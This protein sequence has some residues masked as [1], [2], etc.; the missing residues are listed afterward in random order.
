MKFPQ[1]TRLANSPLAPGQSLAASCSCGWVAPP[2]S[3]QDR[4]GTQEL[5]VQHVTESL[6]P[7]VVRALVARQAIVEL[8]R[9]FEELDHF[10]WHSSN[11]RL[12]TLAWGWWVH[13]NRDSHAL[14]VL[15]AA[16][17]ASEALPVFRSCFEHSLFLDALVRHGESAVDAA[18]AEQARQSKNFIDAAKRGPAA[19]ALPL[20]PGAAAPLQPSPDAAWTQKIWSICE[21]YGANGTLYMIYRL[22]CSMTH[23]TF[24]SAA[25]YL[26]DTKSIDS[27]DVFKRAAD[28]NFETDIIFWT[29]VFLIWAFDAFGKLLAQPNLHDSVT[30]YRRE[31]GVHDIDDFSSL[32]EFGTVDPGMSHERMHVILFGETSE[33]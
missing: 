32:S 29:A 4:D 31:L 6:N 12:M 18:L 30:A 1:H 22:V 9:K 28:L 2:L 11:A 15:F 5:W 7:D 24:S 25:V 10:H 16:G 3:S 17:H 23:P 26:D 14:L 8:G 20:R 27:A 21:R 33:S 13:V 19:S